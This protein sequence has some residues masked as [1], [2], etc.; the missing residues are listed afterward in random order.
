MT[1]MLLSTVRFP[2]SYDL[3]W[4]LALGV[5]ALGFVAVVVL[6]VVNVVRA[7]RNGISPLTSQVDV[8]A[9]LLQSRALQPDRSLDERLVELDD[10]A[11]RGVISTDE[12]RE[13]RAAVL[14]GDHS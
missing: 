14:R 3:V 12:H 8:A 9:R 11:A 6:V 1:D 2:A 5:V 4:S 13:A 10:L 7:R